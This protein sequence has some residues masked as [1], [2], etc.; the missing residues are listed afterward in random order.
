MF[1]QVVQKTSI[2]NN[3]DFYPESSKLEPK[4]KKGV[5]RS[6]QFKKSI[7][8][9]VGE[10]FSCNKEVSIDSDLSGL[11]LV[12]NCVGVAQRSLVIQRQVMSKADADRVYAYME[13]KFNGQMNFGLFSIFQQI[14]NKDGMTYA[15]ATGIV[16]RIQIA[17]ED[18]DEDA[19]QM[20]MDDSQFDQQ[21]K[22]P[23]KRLKSEDSDDDLPEVRHK[24]K[25]QS[26]QN[27]FLLRKDFE[28]EFID[29]EFEESYG[30][31]SYVLPS[32][33]ALED[34]KAINANADTLYTSFLEMSQSINKKKN[35]QSFSESRIR[36][37]EALLILNKKNPEPNSALINKASE[38]TNLY[39]KSN[40]RALYYTN[41]KCLPSKKDHRENEIK[42][43][44]SLAGGFEQ[45]AH[46]ATEKP[47]STERKSG[48]TIEINDRTGK[49]HT[50]GLSYEIKTGQAGRGEGS[51][52][53]GM[54]ASEYLSNVY[55][56]MEKNSII[57][58]HIVTRMAGGR[59]DDNNLSPFPSGDFNQKAIRTPESKAE[60]LLRQDKVIEYSAKVN[61][62]RT[63]DD[64]SSV[65]FNKED[66]KLIGTSV[67][68]K[69]DELKL[70]DGGDGKIISDWEFAKNH[71]DSTLPISLGN[72]VR[73][74]NKGRFDYKNTGGDEFEDEDY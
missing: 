60:G 71:F 67:S 18:E 1:K 22:D 56:L 28:E 44:N 8:R 59:A 34:I 10:Q 6:L 65:G 12:S 50:L 30:H 5:L 68:V 69:I 63:S 26:V 45:L 3:G 36:C 55:G 19:H 43:M 31:L 24:Q 33:N 70:K 74:G 39:L 61:Y 29:E 52:A 37:E 4:R 20:S 14:I 48:G 17:D 66:L 73:G 57:A 46:T 41:K 32:D 49:G 40:L 27:E 72:I 21:Q 23:L 54:T 58:G 47:I 15:E 9:E 64:G 38:L 51:D 16:D 25:N 7:R 13:A 35:P 42:F 62:G 11:G 2:S 53:N